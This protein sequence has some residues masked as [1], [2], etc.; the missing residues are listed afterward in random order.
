MADRTWEAMSLE[1]L[2]AAKALLEAG[3]W[4]DSI[5]RSHYAAYC[6]ATSAVVGRNITFAFGRQNPSHD[7][8]PDLILNTGSLPKAVRQKVKTRL[9][10]LRYIREN[11]D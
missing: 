8:L 2:R 9:Y 6:A 11:A 5:S 1:R 3:F 10:F 4:R 7:Q